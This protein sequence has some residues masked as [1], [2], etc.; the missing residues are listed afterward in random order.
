MVSLFAWLRSRLSS[1]VDDI[2]CL[3]CRAHRTV[4]RVEIVTAHTSKRL[5]RRLVGECRVCGG[6][7]STYIASS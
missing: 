4:R 3:H 7:T 1:L 2:W 6:Q 5:T